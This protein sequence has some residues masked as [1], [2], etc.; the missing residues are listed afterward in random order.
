MGR[1]NEAL[2]LGVVRA[3]VETTEHP[4]ILEPCAPD[5][6]LLT[7]DQGTSKYVVACTCARCGTY[8]SGEQ[9]VIGCANDQ[10]RPLSPTCVPL[11]PVDPPYCVP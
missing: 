10:G 5:Q 11:E 1:E 2:G 8:Q 3:T 4:E 6:R 7:C 9:T